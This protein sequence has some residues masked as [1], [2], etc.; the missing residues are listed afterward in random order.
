MN[1]KQ[2]ATFIIQAGVQEQGSWNR[3]LPHCSGET[4]NVIKFYSLDN[5]ID[6]HPIVPKINW[7]TVLGRESNK[8]FNLI[9]VAG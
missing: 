5:S 3:N 1:T 4:A 8:T 7:L 6:R 2:T 9:A